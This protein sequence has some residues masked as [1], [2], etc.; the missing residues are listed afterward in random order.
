MSDQYELTPTEGGLARL[1]SAI[2]VEERWCCDAGK[3]MFVVAVVAG[4][5]VVAVLLWW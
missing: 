3:L 4:C 5:C 1:P 2:A